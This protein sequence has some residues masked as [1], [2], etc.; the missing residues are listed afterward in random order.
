M[1]AG[2]SARLRH[3]DST[4]SLRP[5]AADAGLHSPSAQ[6]ASVA[7]TPIYGVFASTNSISNNCRASS[8]A[9]R[10]C[11]T[12]STVYTREPIMLPS[13]SRLLA[14]ACW[15]ADSAPVLRHRGVFAR[16]DAIPGSSQLPAIRANVLTSLSSDQPF[17]AAPITPGF[18]SQASTSGVCSYREPVKACCKHGSPK[19]ASPRLLTAAISSS[20][21]RQGQ[22]EYCTGPNSCC[23]CP[24]GC[25]ASSSRHA[26][27]SSSVWSTKQPGAGPSQTGRCPSGCQ[28][29]SGS[30]KGAKCRQAGSADASQPAK[31]R[32]P[33]RLCS[34][35]GQSWHWP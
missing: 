8:Q 27:V 2:G 11:A 15:R 33:D 23:N 20:R 31:C 29:E 19:Q 34:K 17:Q 13:R 25:P 3:A 24:S 4:D 26:A 32:Q 10:T 16:A 6:S 22:R 5:L 1:G 18:S 30:C 28:H 14:G 21:A 7:S 35:A 9:S 12:E